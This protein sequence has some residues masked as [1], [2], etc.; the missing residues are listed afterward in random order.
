[1]IPQ[2]GVFKSP[3]LYSI[4]HPHSYSFLSL[5]LWAVV[6]NAGIIHFP[7]DGELIPMDDYKKCMAVNFFGA[8]E[9][10]KAFL[11]LLRK[12]KGRLVTISS[13]GGES[14]LSH[15]VMVYLSQDW[16]AAFFVDWT[17]KQGTQR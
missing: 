17:R 7:I 4:T 13:M 1:M 14:A 12:S 11:P 6:N 2:F 16:V 15:M 5:G 3:I 8:V 9:V 10:T